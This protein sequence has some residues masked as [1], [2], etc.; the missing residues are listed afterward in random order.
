MIF[1]E[2]MRLISALILTLDE[3]INLPRCLASLDGCRDIVVLDSG[4]VDR[5]CEIARTAGARVVGRCFDDYAGQRNFG[6]HEIDYRHEWV[7]MLDADEVLTSEL[8]AEVT[9][10]VAAPP[11]AAVAAMVR[12][13]DWFDGRW[14]Q[15]ASGYPTWFPRLFRP[16]RV[17]VKR[18]VNER[19]VFRGECVKLNG[20]LLHYPF[21]KGLSAWVDKHNR[22]STAEAALL[23]QQV[24]KL[25]VQDVLADDPL[26]RRSAHK[27][28]F[29]RLPARPVWTFLGLYL[30]RG[31]WL[32]AGSG[33]RF[34]LLRA[35]YEWLIDLKRREL[36]S[37]RNP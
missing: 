24:R 27:A 28:L 12:R 31:G 7:L 34:C 36:R 18:A 21:A 17:H 4:S 25:A 19:Y 26:R 23:E 14:L 13:R 37:F 30:L 20:H 10:F 3:E 5:T 32:D 33:F 35:W 16:D 8:R 15:R 9:G 6:L 11:A 2:E 29:Y 22:Y 1:F